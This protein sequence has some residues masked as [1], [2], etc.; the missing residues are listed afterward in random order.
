MNTPRFSIVI[1]TA[2]R[3]ESLSACLKSLEEQSASSFEVVLVE[4]SSNDNVEQLVEDSPLRIRRISS[5]GGSYAETRN[6]GVRESSGEIVV[7]LDD[8]CI[9]DP[10]WLENLF[11]TMKKGDAAGG[12]TA[13]FRLLPFPEWWSSEL[14]WLLGLSVPG[15]LGPEGG[16]IHYPQTAN[17]MIRKSA[18]ERHRFQEIGGGFSQSRS[19]KYAGREDVELWRRMRI[20]GERCLISPRAVVYHDIPGNRLELKYLI[21]RAFNDGLA[22][23]RREKKDQCLDWAVMDTITLIPGILK[24]LIKENR[25]QKQFAHLLLTR[26]RQW[27]LIYGYLS[28]GTMPIKIFCTA[29]SFFRQSAGYSIDLAKRPVRK[30]IV[31]SHRKKKQKLRLPG[32][33]RKIL[34]AACGFLGDM[35]L[36]MPVLESL[37]KSYPGMKIDLLCGENGKELY[38]RSGIVNDI[39]IYSSDEKTFSAKLAKTIE[40]QAYDAIYAPYYHKKNPRPVFF[41]T[42]VPVITFNR[43]VGLTRKMWYELADKR[44]LKDFENHE[45]R[46]L[47]RMFDFPGLKHAPQQWKIPVPQREREKIK[48][49]L[50]RFSLNREPLIL[51]HPGAGY[52][53]KMWP[54]KNWSELA[55]LIKNNISGSIIFTGG[56]DIRELVE[57]CIAES[58]SGALNLCGKTSLWEL[59]ALLE[60]AEILITTDSGPK[61]FAMSL[62]TPTLTLYGPTDENRWGALWDREKHKVVRAV[63]RDLTPEEMLGLPSDYAMR[64][65]TTEMAFESLKSHLRKEPEAAKK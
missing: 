47:Y 64:C 51:L 53:E 62:G 40:K 12:I 52:P 20:H 9:A 37:R 26:M 41:Q 21:R 33:P 46:N 43:D 55:K 2:G 57:E 3:T 24:T 35:I 56:D 30:C 4:N 49:M 61:H 44:I 59:G 13:P 15:L 14:N 16:S 42:K 39:I 48:M 58:N 19:R 60:F 27:G 10:A 18:L 25:K 29:F 32:K 22:F 45:I 1:L 11:I 54:W 34:V 5:G 7:F 65:I 36:L 38:R 8:D 28:S 31:S 17:M 63:P 6:I 23:Y 50:E